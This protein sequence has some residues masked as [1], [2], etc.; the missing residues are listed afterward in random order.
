MHPE[1]TAISTSKITISTRGSSK[2]QMYFHLKSH[3]LPAP[4]TTTGENPAVLYNP[5]DSLPLIL[6]FFIQNTVSF[7]LFPSTDLSQDASC[8]TTQGTAAPQPPVRG[9]QPAQTQQVCS[10][11]H[12][13]TW[14][15]HVLFV[16]EYVEQ[17]FCLPRLLL[18]PFPYFFSLARDHF[19]SLLPTSHT[20]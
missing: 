15:H 8:P 4:N 5:D 7:S 3:R 1:K 18:S 16:I 17:L 2:A 19:T 20:F 12:H 14:L 11:L 6:D 10:M 9:Y 13:Q